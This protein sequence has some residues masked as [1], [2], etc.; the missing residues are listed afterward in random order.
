MK[1][2]ALLTLTSSLL[3]VPALLGQEAPRPQPPTVPE[4]RI[5]AE[6]PARPQVQPEPTPPA[7]AAP[8]EAPFFAPEVTRPSALFTSPLTDGYRAGSATTGTKIDVPLVNYPGSISVV[9]RDLLN[10]QQIFRTDDL[11]RNITSATKVNDFRRPDAFNLRGFELRSRDFRKDGFLDPTPAPRDLA[12]IERVEVMSGP[13]SV[14]YG[15]GQPGGLVNYITKRAQPEPFA[16]GTIT[17]GSFGFFRTTAD[18]NGPAFDSDRLF[19]RVNIAYETVDGFRDFAFGERFFVAP[20]L[21]WFLDDQTDVQFSFEYLN[22]RRRFDT[23]VV[24][25]G[26]QVG[27]LPISTFLGQPD[28][29][30]LFTDYRFTV[31]LNHRINSDWTARLGLYTQFHDTTMLGTV[32]IS[33]GTPFGLPG[34]LLFRQRQALDPFREQYYSLI[35]DLAGKVDLMGVTHRLVVGTELG[36]FQSRGFQGSF[37]EFASLQP[38]PFPPFFFVA[39]TSPVFA[40]NPDLT[41]GLPQPPLGPGLFT[42]DFIQNRYGFYFQDLVEVAKPL[43]LLAGLRYDIVEQ[44]FDRQ[45]IPVLF[46]PGFPQTRTEDTYFRLTP[47]I[48]AV[49]QPFE[50][51][52]SLY[53]TYSQSFEPPPGGAY[54]NPEPFRPETGELFEV[55]VKA[56]LLSQQ[57]SLTIAAFHLE[58]RNVFVQDDLLFATQVGAQRSQGIETSLAGRVTERWSV[59]A[60]YSY[61]D[62]RIL[63][64]NDPRLIGQRFRGIPYNQSS[65]WS[66][67]N[68]VQDES[69]TLGLAAGMVL[70]GDRPGDLQASFRLPG[71]VRW[72]AGVFY[73]RSQFHVSVYLENVFDREYYVGSVNS[74]AVFPGMPFN[75]RAQAGWRF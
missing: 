15:A 18:V 40:F 49:Y 1:A 14:L 60:N 44:T 74:F 32:P 47:R 55:G 63:A 17:A 67:Y 41:R 5:E 30:Q 51:P 12:N 20:T 37:S 45:F 2:R 69:R 52:L 3:T 22:D 48:G 28:D 7:P 50:E 27:L 59:I 29:R 6:R 61:I 73:E 16:E 31:F 4:T 56:D 9:G 10:D 71:Y 33:T 64:D 53:G 8:A 36:T 57:L 11:I 34:D 58:K 42:A 43:K 38:L 19:V 72:D 35:G 13:A 68:V 24:A 25:L 26:G 39:P 23:G 54:R 66:R 70:V 46:S 65:I 75:I 21:T 62:S